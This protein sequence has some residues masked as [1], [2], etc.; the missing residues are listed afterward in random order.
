[1]LLFVQYRTSPEDE[2][3][4]GDPIGRRTGTQRQILA[5][6]KG[7][8]VYYFLYLKLCYL[9]RYITWRVLSLVRCTNHDECPMRSKVPFVCV[10]FKKIDLKRRRFLSFY[11]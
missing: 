10:L 5:A 9:F 4:Q 8:K 2:E 1:M 7:N 3:T 11:N 6:C